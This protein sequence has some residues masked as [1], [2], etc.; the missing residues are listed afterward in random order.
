[1]IATRWQRATIALLFLVLLAACGGGATPIPTTAPTPSGPRPTTTPPPTIDP[2]HVRTGSAII[3]SPTGQS[4]TG[5]S[6]FQ[7]T[8]PSLP[9]P[10]TI[11]PT[12]PIP[13]ATTGM[14]LTPL[15]N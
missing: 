10:G 6:N 7:G 13:T 5:P 12:V 15:P 9:P 11:P 3:P 8:A 14:I 2:V 1:M 4:A